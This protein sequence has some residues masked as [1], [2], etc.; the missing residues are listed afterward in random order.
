MLASRGFEKEAS[1]KQRAAAKDRARLMQAR[2]AVEAALADVE[3]ARRAEQEAVA[4]AK[5]AAAEV[6]C[7][8]PGSCR[9]NDV[10]TRSSQAP[11]SQNLCR[12]QKLGT[13]RLATFGQLAEWPSGFAPLHIAPQLPEQ[14]SASADHCS[15]PCCPPTCNT[16]RSD[17]VL[18]RRELEKA[19]GGRR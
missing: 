5:E 3:A 12:R 1:G 7:A 4:I 9:Q 15:R 19:V 13:L 16:E 11:K 2:A 8:D 10:R 6:R 18:L 14:S 17:H